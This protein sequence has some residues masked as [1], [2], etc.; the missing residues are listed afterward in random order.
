MPD[1][2]K[3][4]ALLSGGLDS[5]L[6]VKMIIEQGIDVHAVNFTS[7]FCNCSSRKAGCVHQA[8]KVAAEFGV[9]IRVI[10]KGMDYMRIVENAPHGYGRGM[11]PCIDCRIYMLRKVRDL[12]AEIGAGFVITG[13]VLGQRPMS[14]RR[15]A[16]ELIE[17]ESGLA[18]RILRPLSAKFFPPTIPEAEGIV[19]RE[20]LMA[21][22][23]RSRKV[24]I[25]LAEQLG[26]RDYP[27]P[28]GGCLLTDPV[29]AERLRDLFL[30]TPDYTQADL[31]LLTLGRQF[32]LHPELKIVV[33]RVKEENER[34]QKL[35]GPGQYLYS[36]GD[37]RGPSVLAVGIP[38]E[39]DDTT[40]GEIMAGYSQDERSE[41][42]VEKQTRRAQ[43]S[44]FAVKGRFP[45][46]RL[47][48]YRIGA[49]V[50]FPDCPA[51]ETLPVGG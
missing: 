14:Q 23:G 45:R 7:P 15:P 27:C 21:V 47:E 38:R 10:A 51:V 6:A 18:G 37:F 5:T 40:I 12:M 16:I 43:R 39:R 42:L 41:Y 36:P 13:E 19:D 1:R 33:G 48:A 46:R 50:K 3:A 2:P 32:R 35:A 25:E 17:R 8:R 24:Q 26:V 30:H 49:E 28:A 11:N 29:I 22:S 9:P 44:N 20:R 31:V 4:I 34:I